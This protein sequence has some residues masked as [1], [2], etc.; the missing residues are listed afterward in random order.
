MECQLFGIA[1]RTEV[2]G[3]KAGDLNSANALER[4]VRAEPNLWTAA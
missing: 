3:L 1:A 2:A 4:V